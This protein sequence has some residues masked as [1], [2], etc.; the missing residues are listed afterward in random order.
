MII[1]DCDQ[2]SEEWYNARLGIPTA[3][4]FHR[5]LT[6]AGKR[7]K[8]Y[9]EYVFELAG[10]IVS[11][12]KSS[13]YYS[14]DMQRGHE[15]EQESKDYYSFNTGNLVEN[16]G[17]CLVDSREYGCSPDGLIGDEGGFET[18]DINAKKHLNRLKYG[19]DAKEH[20][21]QV[22]GCLMVTERK[23]WDVVSYCRGFQNVVVR[24]EPDLKFIQALKVELKMFHNDLQEVIKKYSI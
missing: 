12:E 13:S 1:I 21:Q 14:K 17:F 2:N 24:V 15:R 7:S 10:E 9:E 16:V 20:F 19:W 6:T 23:W 22:Q 4:Q 5:I 18:K 3:S 8:M 11:G